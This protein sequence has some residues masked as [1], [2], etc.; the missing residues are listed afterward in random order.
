[1]KVNKEQFEQLVQRLLDQKPEKRESLKT[2][3]KKKSATI[4]A[5]RPQPDQQ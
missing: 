5:P 4:I 3:E 1:M 2:G